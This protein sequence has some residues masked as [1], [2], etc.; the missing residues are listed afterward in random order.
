M[1]Q[2]NV[3]TCSKCNDI[4]HLI[5]HTYS[6]LN[7]YRHTRIYS[8]TLRQ[9]PEMGSKVRNRN[10]SLHHS[11]NPQNPTKLYQSSSFYIPH[12][13]SI[14]KTPKRS[15]TKSATR[16]Q[17]PARV[18]VRVGLRAKPR[19]RACASPCT[20]LTQN[21]GFSPLNSKSDYFHTKPSLYNT[22]THL[23]TFYNIKPLH[24]LMID[25]QL[26]INPSKFKP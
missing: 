3:L 6:T 2:V 26:I 23:V 25:D 5:M 22:P 24:N 10:L 9:I 15:R 8:H 16:G 12:M 7:T 21:R 4:K 11:K 1:I 20:I 19:G 17:S 13:M 18:A 14:K